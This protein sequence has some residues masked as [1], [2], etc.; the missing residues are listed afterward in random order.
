MS[1]IVELYLESHVTIEPVFDQRR[2]EAAQIAREF[3]FR[4]AE[5]LMKKDRDATE[6]RSDK[7]T[8]MTGHSKS[9]SDIETRTRGLVNRLKERRLQGVA[10][11]GRGYARGQQARR[12]HLGSTVI[13]YRIC[14]SVSSQA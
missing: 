4:L 13:Q 9:R 14:C 1:D 5:L 11:Q 12:R 10:L 7:D 2:D 8:F 6:V 3:K